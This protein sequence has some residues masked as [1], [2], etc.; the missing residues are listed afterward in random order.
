MTTYFK[1]NVYPQ[2]TI[3]GLCIKNQKQLALD[4]YTDK[5]IQPLGII[6]IK[7]DDVDVDTTLDLS[8]LRPY[9]IE[10]VE[11]MSKRRINA[12]LS[13]PRT[14][15]TP[16]AIM[17]IRRQ[18]LKKCIIVCPAS[19]TYQ[20]QTEC[21]KWH[22]LP[23]HLCNGLINKRNRV[24][25]KWDKEKGFLI[26]SYETLRQDIAKI[27]K[28]KGIEGIILDEAHK[29]KNRKSLMTEAVMSLNKI[30]YRMVLT[31]TPAQNKL[32]DIYPILKFMFPSVFSS[33]WNFINYFFTTEDKYS[34]NNQ[35]SYTEIGGL[36]NKTE[37]PELLNKIAIKRTTKEVMKWLP[38]KD[39]IKIKLN[40]NPLQEKM[41]K[42]LSE[43]FETEDIVVD[44]VLTRLIRYRQICDSPELLLEKPCF[45]GKIEWLKQFI[46]DYPDK[47]IIV[48]S[49]F[50]S[51]L[52]LISKTLGIKPMIIGETSAKKREDLKNAFQ[53]GTFNVL[54]IN[55]VAGKEG[56]TLDRAEACIF[57]DTYP[58]IANIIQAEA[59][60]TATTE[61]KKDKE[62][63]VYQLMMEGTYDE[64]L[65]NL[66]ESC[67]S[68][69]DIVNNF[70]KY[71]N[72]SECK[73]KN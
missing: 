68:E 61:D 45:S 65:Y 48:F 53:A 15:K 60:F 20:W 46:K 44:S 64:T 22:T 25:E 66:T 31:G 69:A 3:N 2:Y 63:T 52:K 39:Y 27:K 54:L 42:E 21:L 37:L 6:S 50:T 1:L 28:I 73:Q 36:K 30:P 43:T 55:T 26:V 10:D 67:M 29:I 18:K 72:T 71:I 32:Y 62:H 13:E 33:Y 57:L 5:S 70:K 40:P 51:F 35:K 38:E 19:I 17:T 9:Q 24:L 7:D 11:K 34:W 49:Y 41:I 16:V 12:N 47:P 4:T 58:P 14:G 56:L 23:V 8:T 59:R